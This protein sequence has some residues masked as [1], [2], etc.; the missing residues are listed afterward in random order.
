MNIMASCVTRKKKN[1]GLFVRRR[2]SS[3][4]ATNKGLSTTSNPFLIRVQSGPM[5]LC[6]WAVMEHG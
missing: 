3:P 4:S 6:D 2:P 1:Q 5:I